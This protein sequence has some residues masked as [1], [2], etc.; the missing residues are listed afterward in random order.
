MELSLSATGTPANLKAISP[1]YLQQVK[2][3][4]KSLPGFP[5]KLETRVVGGYLV[6]E[7]FTEDQVVK[8]KTT[9]AWDHKAGIHCLR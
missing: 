1:A 7:G 5:W 8:Y 4:V 9:R 2:G 6:G 3:W